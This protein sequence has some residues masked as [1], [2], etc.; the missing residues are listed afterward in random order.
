MNAQENTALSVLSY[1][2]SNIAF[3][4]INGRTMVNATQMA[5]PF[6]K[7][8]KPDNWLRTQQAKELVKVVSVSHKCALADLQIV[9]KGGANSG[10]WF[11]EDVALFFAQWLSPEFYLACNEKL[12]ELLT[13]QTLN[14]PAKFGVCPVIHQGKLY[15]SYIEALKAL[16]ASLKSSASKR[17][18]R[19]P[20]HFITLFGRNFITSHCFDL[21]NSYYTYKKGL[22]QLKLELGGANG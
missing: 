7:S 8:K 5:K 10:T 9:R 15:Y 21:L 20:H 1:H 13:Q 3:E 18:K 4:V 6:G 22:H 2:G 12:R 17:K 14:L 19:F 11:H 16:G